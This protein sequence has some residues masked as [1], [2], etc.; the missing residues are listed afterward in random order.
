MLGNYV[1]NLILTQKLGNINQANSKSH[2]EPK[3]LCLGVSF[4]F[5]TWQAL[6]LS[7]FSGVPKRNKN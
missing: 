5:L 2:K 4:G 3:K 6:Y 1:Q 7:T